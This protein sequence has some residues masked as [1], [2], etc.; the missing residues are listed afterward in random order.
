[1]GVG[2]SGF[3]LREGLGEGFDRAPQNRGVGGFGKRAQLTGA[4]KFFGALKMVKP[5]PPKKNP[6]QMMAFLDPLDA[7]IPTIPFSFFCGIL[8]QITFSLSRVFFG[9]GGVN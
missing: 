2:K 1:M 4:E 7:L 5:P 6:W 3:Q 8:G 9:G